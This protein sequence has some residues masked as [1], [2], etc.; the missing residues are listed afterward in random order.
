MGKY[1]TKPIQADLGIFT[2]ILAYADISR[3][4]QPDIIWYIQA[5]PESSV[6]LTYSEPWHIQNPCKFRTGAI[7][8]TLVYSEP[9]HIQNPGLF[10]ALAYL[11]PEIYSEPWYIQNPNIFRTLV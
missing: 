3:H 10:T 6:T 4:I 1:K 11:E 5:Y 8:R 9:W 7:F 2:H